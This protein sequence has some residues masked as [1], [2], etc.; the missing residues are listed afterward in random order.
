MAPVRGRK[1]KDLGASAIEAIEEKED[2]DGKREKE[3][4]EDDSMSACATRW[5]V[6]RSG[7]KDATQ[8][9]LL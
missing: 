7:D 2:D 9:W 6:G 3:D 1:P 4:K 5:R 8:S